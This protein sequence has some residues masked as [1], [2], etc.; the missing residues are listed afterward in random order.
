MEYV[1]KKNPND[2]KI[3]KVI[4]TLYEKIQSN[5]LV[6]NTV[7]ILN[8]SEKFNP[9]YE[10]FDFF[11]F[12]PAR[13]KYIEHELEWYL[14][15]DKSI[16][17]H[18]GIENNKIWQYTASDDE[19]HEVNSQY[20]FLVFSKENGVD[21]KSQFELA[22]EQILK[23]NNTRQAVIH[24]SRTTIW[25]EYNENGKHDYI[26]TFNTTFEVRNGKLYMLVYMRSNALFTGFVND[27]AWQYFVYNKMKKE[28]RKSGLKLKYGN[29]F[30]NAASLHAQKILKI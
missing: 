4:K 22:K 15:L 6:N 8:Y 25:K 21:G 24:Y 9:K 23:D 7:E 12:R 2:K 26:C 16:T 27:Y 20:G 29:I 19:L 5:E 10:Y 13:R 17:N 18:P 14:S 28:L 11:G 3:F 1:Y 30:W